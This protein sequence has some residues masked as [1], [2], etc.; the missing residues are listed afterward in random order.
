MGKK[1]GSEPRHLAWVS[2]WASAKSRN[3]LI[4]MVLVGVAAGALSGALGAWRYSALIGWD[5]AALTFSGWSWPVLAGMDA[6]AT[7]AHARSEDPT[8]PVTDALLLTA[9]VASLVA[10][11]VV[12]V[13]ASSTPG[14]DKGVLAG[15]GALSVAVSWLLVHTLFTLRYARIYHS[16]GGGVDFNQEG[17]PRYVDFAYLAFTIG[18]T[19][20]VSDTNL[21]SP[22]IRSTA[23]RH[24]LLSY[25]FGA[26]IL[27]TAVNFIVSLSNS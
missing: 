15:L 3:R 13:A 2:A 4:V 23:L 9:S 22:A 8:R 25:L 5:A 27:A 1:V 12:L 10:V 18:M 19:F 26:V 7:E 6:D 24:A 16:R 14:A 11:G 17:P 21:T 20:Q